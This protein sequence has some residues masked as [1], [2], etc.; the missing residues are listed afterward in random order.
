MSESLGRR[1]LPLDIFI[2][3]A[4]HVKIS[5]EWGLIDIQMLIGF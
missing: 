4:E 3:I 5:N 2:A 1:M